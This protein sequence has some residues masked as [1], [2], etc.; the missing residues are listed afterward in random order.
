MEYCQAKSDCIVHIIAG[1]TILFKTMNGIVDN[2]SAI[3]LNETGAFLWNCLQEK[4]TK[5]EL[6]ARLCA[7]YGIEREIATTD[8]EA[9]LEKC[10]KEDIVLS[11]EA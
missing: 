10:I 6:T 9:F 3:V 1:E 2:N 7:K 5:E 8:T 4:T 11:C